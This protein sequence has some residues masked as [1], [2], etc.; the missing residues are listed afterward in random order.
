MHGVFLHVLSDAL[1]S[2]AV[3]ASSL[4]IMYS[5]GPWRF[6]MDPLISV[7]IT[8]MIIASTVPLVKSAGM[9]VLQGVPQS[10]EVERLRREIL[11]LEGVLDVHEFHVWALSDVK[12]V[13]SVHVLVRDPDAADG[14]EGEAPS[15]MDIASAIKKILHAHGIHSTTVQ[16]EFVKHTRPRAASSSSSSPDPNDAEDATEYACLLKCADKSCEMRE[17]CPSDGRRVTFAPDAVTA[18][19]DGE[20]VDVVVVDGRV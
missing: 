18:A 13:A 8:L 15:Y 2:L 14:G 20:V 4:I 11:G 7:L 3:I 5:S 10:V 16:P 6:Y 19:E 17:C 1:G 9:I 12:V